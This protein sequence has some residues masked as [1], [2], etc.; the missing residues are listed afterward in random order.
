MDTDVAGDTVV[1][2]IPESLALRRIPRYTLSTTATQ[3]QYKL[4][5]VV[6]GSY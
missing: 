3:G 2:I 4:V 5:G 1:V 6:P